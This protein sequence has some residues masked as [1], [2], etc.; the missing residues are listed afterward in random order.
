MGVRGDNEESSSEGGS[1]NSLQMEEMTLWSDG[2]SLTLEQ[3]NLVEYF[4]KGGE[5][6]PNTL[7][8]EAENVI[9]DEENVDK[10]SSEKP[11]SSPEKAPSAAADQVPENPQVADEVGPSTGTHESI[12]ASPSDVTM[13]DGKDTAGTIPG[14]ESGGTE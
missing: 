6:S 4:E 11:R 2:M 8:R 14:V 9:D 10:H 3:Q 12:N 1:K 5:S 7:L 13:D